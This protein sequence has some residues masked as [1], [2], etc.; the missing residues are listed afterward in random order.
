MTPSVAALC[1]AGTKKT[2]HL[3]IEFIVTSHN[4]V[5]TGQ[6][7][8]VPKCKHKLERP[9]GS[10]IQSDCIGDSL[11]LHFGSIGVSSGFSPAP[12]IRAHLKL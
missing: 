12:F 3:H 2:K 4:S 8:N 9:L 11:G 7:H 6:D 10:A 1:N 5:H